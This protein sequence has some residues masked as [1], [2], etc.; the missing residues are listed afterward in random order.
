MAVPM[1]LANGVNV[2]PERRVRADTGSISFIRSV[3]RASQV[4]T[5]STRTSSASIR[6]TR[7]AGDWRALLAVSP[8]RGSAGAKSLLVVGMNPWTLLLIDAR[9]HRSVLRPSIM[10]FRAAQT[11]RREGMSR[12]VRDS[13]TLTTSMALDVRT[14]KNLWGVILFV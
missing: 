5:R 4:R 11:P 10:S 12:A 6:H 8:L 13:D 9:C 7:S 1:S 3:E 14:A 2:Q